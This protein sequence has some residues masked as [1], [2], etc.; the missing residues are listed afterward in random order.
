MNKHVLIL[1]L[2]I[3]LLLSCERKKKADFTIGVSQ[4]SDDLWRKTMN[5]E[6]LREASFYQDINIEIDIRTVKDNTQQ[7]IQDIEALIEQGVDL[8]VISPNESTS[9]T[10]IVQKAFRKNIP[11]ILIDRRIDTDDY[12][13]YIGADN[14]QIGKEAGLYA[15]SV[16]QEKGN[17]VEIRGWN[18]STSDL[19]RHQ[20]FQDAIKI[21]SNI[22]IIAERRGNFLKEEAKTQM[23]DILKE[24]N[25]IDLVF[26]MNDPMALGV[27]EAVSKYSGKPPFIIGID[28]LPGT[29]GGIESIQKGL[30][31]ASFIYPTGGDKVIDLAINILTN[32]PYERENT[33]RTAVV[34]KDNVRTIQLQ[35]EQI[36]E[37]QTKLELMSDLLNKNLTQYSN[38]RT[39]FYATIFILILILVLLLVSIFAYRS[40]SKINRLLEKQNKEI[41]EQADILTEQKEQLLALSKQ[42]EDATQA[43]LVFFT[44]IS[45]EFRT[46]LSLIIGPIETLLRA[47]NLTLQQ[48]EL[49]S[50]VK[51]N[52]NRLLRLI[53]QIIEFRSFENGKMKLYL[54]YADLVEFISEMNIV[55]F[56]YATRLKINFEFITETD[57]LPVFF[58]KEKVEKIYYNLLSNAFKHTPE[59]G[60]IRISLIT[61]KI[62]E[63]D[64]V[65]ITV[66]NSGS[67]IPANKIE[68]IFDRFYKVNIND[69]GSGIGLALT[70]SLV[71]VHKGTIS[72]KSEE[73][74][75]TTFSVLLPTQ[76]DQDDIFEDRNNFTYEYTNNLF[77]I[78]PQHEQE[79][80]IVDS[81]FSLDKPIA[82]LIEDNRDMQ[83]YMY[84]ILQNDYNII[85]A[86]DGESGVETAIKNIPDV[87][88]CDVMMPRR[89]GFEVCEIL[90]ENMI[91]C[92]IPII[93]LTACSLDEQKATGFESGADAYISKPFNAELLK[94][95]LRKLIEN[96]QKIKEAYGKSLV[97]ETKRISLTEIEQKFFDD[98]K[99]YVEK[100]MDE[101]EINIDNIASF[102]GLSR[103]QLYR[104]IKS[105]TDYS[106]NELV[107]VIKLKHAIHLLTVERKSISEAAYE[108]GFSS[109][110]YF[111]KVF[112][113]YYN[114]SPTDFLKKY[115]D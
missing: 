91:T 55:F 98:F 35:T 109:P 76:Y 95:R 9:I 41:K 29:G 11:V 46:P 90:K 60:S 82:L 33:L 26:A 81:S 86:M 62:K 23:A 45:H 106:P 69:T 110:S 67:A 1:L 78:E 102:L 6:M 115:N 4:C 28:A 5:N 48:K 37:H 108:T 94:I 44:N 80:F 107:N 52:S 34:D 40:K 74:T 27:H 92:H 7:Q 16:L 32:K 57:Y 73:G 64:F 22:H 24:N 71:D 31:D 70:S 111:T 61:R 88:V 19:E 56:D 87:I 104:K 20:G 96:R 8:L 114:D 65:E 59:N 13:A 3:F 66:F 18:G 10:P 72:V 36:G 97:N 99:V 17:I 38:Q 79:K 42:L 39:L 15:V 63:N 43:K 103:A 83:N 112:K 25:R 77:D 53:S 85:Q 12:T 84:Y 2:P 105:V 47:N 58:D 100:H 54:N 89:D 49:L 50:L 75:G 93:L 21:Y 68:N 14:Y 101:T 113:K 30:I 51:R